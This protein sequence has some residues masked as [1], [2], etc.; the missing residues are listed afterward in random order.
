MKHP[1]I[2]VRLFHDV[3]AA[4][5][6]ALFL[7]WPACGAA[8]ADQQIKMSVGEYRTIMV[9]S[10]V[11]RVAVA[12]PD[13]ADYTVVSKHEVLISGKTIGSTSV[14]IWS[15]GRNATYA[16]TVRRNPRQVRMRVRI[17]EISENASKS[18][19]VDWGAFRH[20]AS[21]SVFSAV[22]SHDQ[23][24]LSGSFMSGSLPRVMPFKK[25]QAFT[26]MDPFMVQINY[27]IESGVIKILS[28]PEVVALSGA[29]SDVLIGGQVPVPLVTQNQ[30]S[31]EWKDYGI[32][33]SME[34]VIDDDNRISAKIYTEVSTLDFANAV[35]LTGFVLP[36]LKITRATSEISVEPG[37]TIFLSGLK[38]EID[39]KSS[40][41]VPGLSTMPVVGSV[42]GTNSKRIDRVDLII[43]VTPYLVEGD[44]G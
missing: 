44:G 39:T 41:G 38:R 40:K 1:S 35:T 4:A 27:L 29:R 13:V 18:F 8:G 12:A 36:A 15:G 24:T 11:D 9:D 30:I 21:P 28:E 32:K 16:V 14:K 43:S 6:V 26:A 20:S 37:K 10:V 42:F 2:F 17:M 5:T 34:P 31:V 23:Y 22:N 25:S 3:R 33:M 19:G 7:A